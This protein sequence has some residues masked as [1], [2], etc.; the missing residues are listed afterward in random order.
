MYPTRVRSL[1]I[2][3]HFSSPFCSFFLLFP[4]VLGL[5]A[6]AF[7]QL[8]V[9]LLL[10]INCCCNRESNHMIRPVIVFGIDTA[11]RFQPMMFVGG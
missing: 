2:S 7:V 11:E 5:C 4:V 6:C 1:D 3:P 8:L 10:H 9:A